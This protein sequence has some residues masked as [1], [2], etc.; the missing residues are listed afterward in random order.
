MNEI[1]IHRVEP[2]DGAMLRQVRLLALATDPAS[3]GSTYEREAAFPNEV[4]AERAQRGSRGEDATT[5]IAIRRSEPVGM[6]TG[7]RDEARPDLFHVFGT[8]V[9]P[10]ARR[11]GLG[12]QLLT[13]IERWAVECGGTRI[14][15]AV[16]DTATAARRLYARE[17]YAPDGDFMESAHI[18]GVHETRLTKQVGEAAS[19]PVER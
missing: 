18:P 14:Q 2:S 5:L 7:A 6:I 12:R 15:L 17:G 9:A 10:D 8:W 3:F 4:W 13:G 11:G 1:I 16:T 19:H